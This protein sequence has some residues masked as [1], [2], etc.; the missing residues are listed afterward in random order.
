MGDELS[1]G[2]DSC[3]VFIEEDNFDEGDGESEGMCPRKLVSVEPLYLSLFA[4]LFM[5]GIVRA[6][7]ALESNCGNN[8]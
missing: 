1:F 7:G 2:E 5:Y 8:S 4:F 6:D 3:D